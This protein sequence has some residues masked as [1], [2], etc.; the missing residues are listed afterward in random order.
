M[1]AIPKTQQRRPIRERLKRRNRN[2][3]LEP[4]EK[5]SNIPT[6]PF[7]SPVPFLLLLFF[8]STKKIPTIVRLIPGNFFSPREKMQFSKEFPFHTVGTF[9]VSHS[10]AILQKRRT[11]AMQRKNRGSKSYR[12]YTWCCNTM[13]FHCWMFHFRTTIDR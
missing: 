13:E 7:I 3:R 8:F 2:W 6:A 10:R 5:A 11:I 4:R 12:R 9:L 1:P